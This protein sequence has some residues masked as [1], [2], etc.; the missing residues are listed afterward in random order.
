MPGF[1]TGNF[2]NYIS[3]LMEPRF[4]PDLRM[5]DLLQSLTMESSTIKFHQLIKVVTRSFS[6]KAI[7]S[8]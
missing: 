8:R 7:E 6:F 3:I 1:A 4:L 5:N 2:L